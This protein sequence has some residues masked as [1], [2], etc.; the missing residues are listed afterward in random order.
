[1]HVPFSAGTDLLTRAY[2]DLSPQLK[3]CAAY[4][5]EHP[6]EVATLSMRQVAARARV[7]PS[8]MTRL[9]K[10]LNL[11]TYNN[12][13]ALYRD[14]INENYSAR[15]GQLQAAE[16]SLD[17]TL[18]AFRQATLS[19]LNTLFD[20]IDRTALDRAIQA[21]TAARHVL[22]IGMHA[23][24]SFANYLHYVAAMGFHN[25]HLV[26]RRNG[27]YSYLVETL[28][29]ADVVVAIALKPC[30]TDTVRIARR[31]RNSGA[32]VVGITDRRTSPLAAC[33][34][35]VPPLQAHF[36]IGKDWCW[37]VWSWRKAA[38]RWSTISTISSAFAVKWAS[39]GRS[40]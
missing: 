33:S 15:A 24:Y 13:R 31:A 40:E 8:T 1:M 11:G 9:A 27:E 12:F 2:P 30:A 34:D 25:W 19:N 38:A 21:L 6:S 28:A 10:S 36:W 35:D 37:P 32:R 14:S 16:T 7:P 20:H 5:L 23:S 4:L 17:H 3:T 26:D 39:I 22:V 29:P 18:D